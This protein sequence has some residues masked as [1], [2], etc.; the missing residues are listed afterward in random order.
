MS[1]KHFNRA[2]VD[3]PAHLT[4]LGRA[5]VNSGQGDKALALVADALAAAP[6]DPM[7]AEA[8]A[9]VL[10]HQ[11]PHFHRNMLNDAARNDA[12]AAAIGIAIQGGERVLDIGTGSGLLAMM[13][14]R[15]GAA[16]IIAAESNALL[17]ATAREIV[18]A[19]GF[20]AIRVMSLASGEID[21]SEIG[22]PV[23]VIIHE[24]F[25][26][27]LI[28]EGVLPTLADAV[29]RLAR[30][31][32]KTVPARASIRVALAHYDRAAGP[33]LPAGAAA[34]YDLSLFARH[35]P[36]EMRIAVG[37][38]H[39]QLRSCSHDLFTFD[40]GKPSS[41]GAGRGSLAAA[42]TGGD[43][44][45][46]VQWLHVDFVEGL[47][48]ENR[49]AE[50]AASHWKAVFHPIKEQ[51]TLL[52]EPFAIDGWHDQFALRIWGGPTTT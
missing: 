41:L 46:I 9:V 50:G 21:A 15:A 29:S 3:H 16:E 34:A 45:G 4:K 13:A 37:S 33:A 47:V 2:F 42:S 27:N 17:A 22:G 12:Y 19:N 43:V 32:V 30:P 52:G 36:S 35:T 18:S 31:G 20:P 25:G 7:V 40:F 51:E 14:A 44:N 23:D 11:V 38:Q 6:D 48:Y 24:I 1:G 10:T 49:P 5:L 39:L 26:D 28:E 8:A